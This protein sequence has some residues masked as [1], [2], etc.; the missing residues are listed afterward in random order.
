MSKNNI[1]LKVFARPINND[2][3][4]CHS[5]ILGLAAILNSKILGLIAMSNP[6]CTDH[7]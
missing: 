7:F 6:I 1:A 2:L 3:S 4:E 5:R